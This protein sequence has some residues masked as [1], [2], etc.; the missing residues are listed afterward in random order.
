MT[1]TAPILVVYGIDP[2]RKPRCWGSVQH[3][4]RTRLTVPSQKCCRT[5]TYSLAATALSG[6]SGSLPSTSFL[7]L[8]TE[9]P[10]QYQR[11]RR[12]DD[13]YIATRLSSD[14][15]SKRRAPPVRPGWPDY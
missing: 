8:S 7:P 5:G 4:S 15:R 3:G 9:L 12:S 10:P 1:D 14:L 6:S 11:R 2:E 13:R